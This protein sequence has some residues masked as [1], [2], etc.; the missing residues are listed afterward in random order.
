MDW[1]IICLKEHQYPEAQNWFQKLINPKTQIA[2]IRNGLN[3]KV[4]LLDFTVEKRI[5]ECMI[6]CP[7]QLKKNEFYERIRKPFVI[8]P[9]SHLAND[10]EFLFDKY[11][12]G[13]NQVEDFKTDNWKKLCE[14]SSLG[15][16]LCLSGETCWIF[17]D[18]KMRILYRDIIKETLLVAQADGAKIES[19]F[20]DEMLTKLMTYP[21]TKGSSML[22]D[23]LNGKPIELGAKNGVISEL[24]KRHN[25]KTPINNL[26]VYLLSKTNL[27]HKN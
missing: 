16:I 17:K 18:E 6:D 12:I 10:F 20:I 1:L 3:L 15:A 24:G 26:I 11:S 9:K 8:V 19:N 4:P 7:T 5:L 2:V 21:E 13:I 14:S 25:I 22:T 27:T 23:R